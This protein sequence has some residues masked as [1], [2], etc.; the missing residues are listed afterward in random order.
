MGPG[1]PRGA[2]WCAP[3]G[4]RHGQ[5]GLRSLRRRS[6]AQVYDP[7]VGGLG[8]GPPARLLPIWGPPRRRPASGHPGSAE[9]VL[10]VFRALQLATQLLLEAQ[11]RRGAVRTFAEALQVAGARVL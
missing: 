6:A 10:P 4:L 1:G 11:Q 9:E 8:G 2:R 7:V 5:L 3:R